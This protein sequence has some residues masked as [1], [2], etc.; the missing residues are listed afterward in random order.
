VK[1]AAIALGLIAALACACKKKK[2]EAAAGSATGGSGSAA[3]MT[4]PV[5]AD[6]L[7]QTVRRTKPGLDVTRLQ[8]DY[9]R[10]DGTM[11]PTYGHFEAS[12]L[13]P[14]PGPPPDDP[15]RPTGAPVMTPPPSD[16]ECLDQTWRASSGWAVP[17]SGYPVMCMSFGTP[18]PVSCTI[19]EVWKRAIAEGAPAD[20]LAKIELMNGMPEP[21][22]G[23]WQFSIYDRPRDVHFTGSYEDDCPP[24]VEAP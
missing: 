6:V 8:I 1:R 2:E 17:P 7:I 23:Q 4:G 19:I 9:V 13:G 18:R 20:A 12:L 15:N 10:S 22:R 11:D 14:E 3:A 5:L 16:R 21:T 24:R